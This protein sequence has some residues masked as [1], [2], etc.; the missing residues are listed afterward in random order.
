MAKTILITGASTGI[1]K[2]TAE[3]FAEK[4]WNVAATMRSPEK[5]DLK[6]SD[7]LKKFKLD[8]EDKTSIH[9]AVN[10]VLSAFGGI[11]VV[12]NNAG[13][14]AYGPLEAA[15]DAQIR[16]QFEV[17]VFGL[18]E[19]TRAV[20]PHLRSKKSGIIINVTSVGGKITTPLGSLYHGTKWGVEGISES[21]NYEL[22]PLGIK[23]RII[24]PGGIKT[25]FTTRSLDLFDNHIP[26]Y[27]PTI[28]AMMNTL[29]S[30]LFAQ[31]G[32]E[33]VAKVAYKA[34]TDTSKR[35]RYI[36]GMDAKMLIAMKGL[37]GSRTIMGIIKRMIKV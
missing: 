23:V 8:V 28:D 32:P 26:E 11:D 25:D 3:Y 20:L 34:A 27:Q 2:A 1:G 4:G 16:R 15:T 13:Y 6:E 33:L 19:V 17:N 18:L 37:F 10:S 7:R 30:D 22:N 35:I 24:E 36:A 12:L 29:K 14:G 31:S 5:A 21:L 9:N